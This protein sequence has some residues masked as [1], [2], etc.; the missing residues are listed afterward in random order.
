V[1]LNKLDRFSGIWQ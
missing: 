1:D